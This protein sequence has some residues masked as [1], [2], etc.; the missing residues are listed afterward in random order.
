MST[1]APFSDKEFVIDV[2]AALIP[3]GTGHKILKNASVLVSGD[4]IVEVSDSPIQHSGPRLELT[5]QLLMPGFISSHCHVASGAPTRGVIEPRRGN[6]TLAMKYA[7][8]LD[9]D[10]LDAMTAFNL[11]EL[12]RTGC[13]TQVEMALSLR[14][15]ESYVRVAERFG[16][17]GYPSGMI[18]GYARLFDM[19]RTSHGPLKVFSDKT[20]NAYIPGTM[21]EIEANRQFGLRWNHACD[22]RIRPMMGPHATDTHTPE[23]MGAIIRAAKELGNGI[24]IHMAQSANESAAVHRRWGLRSVEWV[25]SLGLFDVPVFGAHMFGADLLHDPTILANR[26]YVFATCP[27][28]TGVNGNLQPYPEMLAAG[29]AVG[30]GVD[31]HNMDFIETLKMAV[32]KGQARHNSI[33]TPGVPSQSP[34]I[35]DAVLGATRVTADALGR[36]DLGRIEAGAKAD[37]V[38]MDVSGMLVGSGVISP[39]PLSNLLYGNGLQVR[40]VLI[41]GYWKVFDGEIL[42][43]D[44]ETLARESGRAAEKVWARLRSAGWMDTLVPDLPR[45]PS[46]QNV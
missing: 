29:V 20:F 36:P 31:G 27:F 40:N 4:R 43:A 1:N 8:E 6:Y 10:D 24:Q 30:I 39:E 34:T 26:S 38:S 9:D 28:D 42:F 45:F 41:D 32:V 37:L 22:D 35:D 11:A 46:E 17:R 15:A 16:A 18:P 12:I 3:D 5:G 25:D 2:S 23:T 7:D 21:D 33:S 44:V 13:T 19:W 14:Q